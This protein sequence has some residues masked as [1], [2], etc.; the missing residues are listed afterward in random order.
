[1][2]QELR[3]RISAETL[4]FL[5]VV[6]GPR[7]TGKSTLIGQIAE[8]WNGSKQLASADGVVPHG[9]DWITF[10]W[11]KACAKPGITLLAIDEIQKVKNWSEAIKGLFDRDRH[12]NKLRVIL[13][14][15]ASLTL[16]RGLTESLAG[17]FELIRCP[18][19][20]H[21]ETQHA[22]GWDL[23]THLKFGGYPAPA[24]M[25]ESPGRWM[26]F[27]RESIIEPVLGRDLQSAVQIQKPALFRQ[28]FSLAMNYPAQEIS[29]QKLL[30][31]L[32][33][34]GNAATIKHYLEVLKGG[35]LVEILEKY[36]ESGVVRKSSS[37][38]IIPMA[39]ALIHAFNDPLL[40]DSDPE[41]RGR[42]FEAAIGAHLVRSGCEL[43]YWRDDH[44]EI[45]FVV[46][47]GR[48]VFGIEVK[49]GRRKRMSGAVHFKKQFPDAKLIVLDWSS[50]RQF[51]STVPSQKTLHLMV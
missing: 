44:G 39:P 15:S 6:I 7:Q 2:Y 34:H 49:S 33:D 21:D 13:S 3:S 19:W 28:L 48:E 43:Y 45:D 29:Y 16:Q 27:M 17:R 1:M 50:G 8:S 36:S 12:S 5:Q 9:P 31:Q 30:G 51:L 26:S 42:V 24:S 11:E 41:W 18:H 10:L 14:G 20:G 32:Q 23:E 47:W 22:F 35:F 37:P 25:I 46:K 4:P 40:V 38:K